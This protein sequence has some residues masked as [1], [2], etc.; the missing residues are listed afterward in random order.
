MQ[1]FRTEA[2]IAQNG[3]LSLKGLP[4]HKGDQVEIIILTQKR[5]ETSE[6]YPLRQKQ[7]HY[8]RPFDGVSENDWTA[9]R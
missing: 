6:R 7:V 9:L 1:A 8:E 2:V 5:K 3:K 4:F